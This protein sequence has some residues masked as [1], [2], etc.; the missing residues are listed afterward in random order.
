[1]FFGEAYISGSMCTG[2]L[3]PVQQPVADLPSRGSSG[4]S[5]AVTCV[6]HNPRSSAILHAHPYVK[7]TPP[8]G[9]EVAM[10]TAADCVAWLQHLCCRRILQSPLDW[11]QPPEGMHQHAAQLFTKVAL[12][13]SLV[14]VQSMTAGIVQSELTLK[15]GKGE[16]MPPWPMISQS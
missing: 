3:T 7:P 5:L 12:Q 8:Q 2:Q 6:V 9:C 15:V 1:M 13:Q 16:Y 10:S 14:R 11:F 4:R